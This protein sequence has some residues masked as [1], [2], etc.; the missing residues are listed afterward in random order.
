MVHITPKKN[1]G[2][3]RGGLAP[4]PLEHGNYNVQKEREAREWKMGAI[5]PL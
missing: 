5:R 2:L 4:F 3:V 1:L